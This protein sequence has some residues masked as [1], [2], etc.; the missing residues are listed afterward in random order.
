MMKNQQNQNIEITKEKV[1]RALLV[2]IDNGI[3]EDEAMPVLQAIGYALLDMELEPFF[4]NDE[5]RSAQFVSRWDD[6]AEF[7]STCTVNVKT[8]KITSV[9]CAGCPSPDAS[10]EEQVVVLND[11]EYPVYEDEDEVDDNGEEYFLLEI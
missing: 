7:T 3:D 4:P 9:G 11:R 1:Q 8:R 5:I 6:G 10:L 2:L